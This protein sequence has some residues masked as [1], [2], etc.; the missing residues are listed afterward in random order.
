VRRISPPGRYKT[1]QAKNYPE[2]AQERFEIQDRIPR[3]LK[4]TYY[5]VTKDAV[6]GFFDEAAT[7]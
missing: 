6:K 4:P 1:E 2:L 5:P 7:S 3:R